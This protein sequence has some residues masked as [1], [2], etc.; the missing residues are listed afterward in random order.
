MCLNSWPHEANIYCSGAG[1]IGF[2]GSLAIKCISMNNKSCM[3]K[4]T[5]IDFNPDEF[6]HYPLI[7]SMDGRDGSFNN[8]E[9]SFSKICLASKME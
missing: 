5:L 4:V 6:R 9:D 8:I 7:V 3:V 1:L 2:G